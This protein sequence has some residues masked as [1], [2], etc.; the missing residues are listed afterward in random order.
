MDIE[1]TVYT[2]NGCHLCEDMEVQLELLSAE[3]AFSLRR[4]DID[5]QPELVER[6]GARVPVLMKRDQFIC[7]YFLDQPALMQ[8]LDR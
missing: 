3:L 6:F 4:I 5:E 7:E 2:R 8:A 1:L